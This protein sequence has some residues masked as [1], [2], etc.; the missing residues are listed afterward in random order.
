MD[1]ERLSDDD[2]K[3]TQHMGWGENVDLKAGEDEFS[4]S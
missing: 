2:T 1:T 4:G 3:R